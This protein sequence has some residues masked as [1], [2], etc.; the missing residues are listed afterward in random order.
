MREN[1]EFDAPIE[2]GKI[3]VPPKYEAVLRNAK[4]AHVSVSA[5]DQPEIGTDFFAEVRRAPIHAPHFR[6]FT[7]DEMHER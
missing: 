6:H 4:Q 5:E 1:I 2:D 3:V 7:R